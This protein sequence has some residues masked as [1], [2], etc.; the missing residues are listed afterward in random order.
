VLAD[1]V[2]WFVRYGIAGWWRE[3]TL[4]I[5]SCPRQVFE[6]FQIETGP[7]E[8]EEGGDDGQL[9]KLIDAS[10]KDAD[11]IYA[12]LQKEAKVR[13]TVFRTCW[14]R[15]VRVPASAGRVFVHLRQDT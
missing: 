6:K 9:D 1:P 15:T 14:P 2:W 4:C 10:L 12:K 7:R 11:K 5:L 13:Y 3:V 8:S